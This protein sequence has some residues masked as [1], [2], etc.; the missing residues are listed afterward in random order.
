MGNI[1]RI[2][3]TKIVFI[4]FLIFF[5]VVVVYQF[6]QLPL[7]STPLAN[8]TIL[9]PFSVGFGPTNL[10][11]SDPGG[12]Y[13]ET[14]GFVGI[15]I[16]LIYLT[17]VRP[18]QRT[19][20]ILT[21]SPYLIVFN[22]I[23]ATTFVSLASHD[24]LWRFSYIVPTGLLSA[25]VVLHYLTK[26]SR[27]ITIC[28]IIILLSASYLLPKLFENNLLQSTS[29]NKKGR[30]GKKNKITTRQKKRNANQVMRIGV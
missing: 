27:S 25:Y 30:R 2:T 10:F 29:A 21:I 23:A 6:S 1:L 20:T 8:N 15:A 7:I 24:T 22:P 16:S 19:L 12:R 4:L 5:I 28:A 14:V 17:L 9:L 3:P 13:Y 26:L 11:V 18:K